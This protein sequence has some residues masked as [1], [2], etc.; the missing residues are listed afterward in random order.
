MQTQKPC[1]AYHAWPSRCLMPQHRGCMEWVTQWIHYGCWFFTRWYILWPVSENTSATDMNPLHNSLE[2]ETKYIYIL[3]G[4]YIHLAC[5]WC[6]YILVGVWPS[7]I[8]SLIPSFAHASCLSNML[9]F[10][11]ESIILNIIITR[12]L[13][14]SCPNALLESNYSLSFWYLTCMITVTSEFMVC[15]FVSFLDVVGRRTYPYV[16]CDKSINSKW[17][18]HL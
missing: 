14:P 18:L 5:C 1:T 9:L 10:Q 12:A 8:P 3:K 15:A 6:A 17:C 4:T 13:K 7:K 11:N 2:Y 16:A